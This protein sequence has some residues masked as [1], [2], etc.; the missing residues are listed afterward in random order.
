MP[1]DAEITAYAKKLPDI[2]RDIMAA[3]PAIEPG[4]KA[5][6][7]M[8]FQTLT[9]Y[10]ANTR[11]GYGMGEVQEACTR[12]AESGFL[13]IK[14]DIFAFPTN[15]GEQLIAAV[16]NRPR[17]SKSVVPNLPAHTW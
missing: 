15:L 9:M 7:G 11:K 1:S 4:R 8:A 17:A 16:T 3:F 13:E 10:F 12:L 14:N 6:N 5:G 2:Y